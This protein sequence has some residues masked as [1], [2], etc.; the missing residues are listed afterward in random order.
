[1]NAIGLQNLF[2]IFG[3]HE[4]GDANVIEI[5]HKGR[6]F[7][8]A[9]KRA[10]AARR[11]TLRV[12]GAT[13]D[14]VLTMPSKA[15][16]QQAREFAERH[17]EWLANRL[18]RLPQRAPFLPGASIPLRGTGHI[19]RHCSRPGARLGPVWVDEFEG[20]P[21]I[22]ATGQAAHF[23]R[24]ITDFLRQEARRDL[25]RAVQR[26]AEK[27]GQKPISL[28]L[29]DTSSRWGS[30]SAKGA[31]NFSWRLILAPSFVL[32]YLAAHEVA[33]LRH[34]D[35]SEK[36]WALTKSLCPEMERAEAWLK[37]HGAQLH[38]Y[39]RRAEPSGDRSP[40]SDG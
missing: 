8:I 3:R 30:C 38:R 1:M 20:A 18:A 6:V 37:V 40:A 23:E 34:H 27:I 9:L 11:F 4:E 31:L 21:C 25:E 10:S 14:I 33:H 15:S 36:F 28:S 7:T 39:G 2:R 22:C 5:A 13:S 19:L 17:G 12:R 29:R 24:R 35:H 16:R 26:H 32:D